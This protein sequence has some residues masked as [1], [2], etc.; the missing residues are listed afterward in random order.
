MSDIENRQEYAVIA[1]V[2][3]YRGVLNDN[4]GWLWKPVG[5]STLFVKKF[6]CTP[7]EPCSFT[8]ENQF[9]DF[10]LDTQI[11]Q[12]QSAFH[13]VR[14]WFFEK[15]PLSFF[16]MLPAPATSFRVLGVSV[17]LHAA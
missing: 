11:D 16:L 5:D 14:L 15:S 2:L 8:D 12:K 13:S 10:T 1:L 9:L 3:P 6:S 7:S 17:S 4:S